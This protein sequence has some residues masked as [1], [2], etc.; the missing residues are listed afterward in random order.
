MHGVVSS[1]QFA[2]LLHKL[3][4][5]GNGDYR[6]MQ[7]TAIRQWTFHLSAYFITNYKKI[8]ELIFLV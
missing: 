8:S 5:C 2:G 3:S 6:T 4:V 7:L 1:K